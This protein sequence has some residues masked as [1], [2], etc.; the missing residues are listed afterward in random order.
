MGRSEKALEV[1]VLHCFLL[2]D[3]YHLCEETICELLFQAPFLQSK[4]SKSN[5]LL[6]RIFDSSYMLHFREVEPWFEYL[7][8]Q[9]MVNVQYIQSSSLVLTFPTPQGCEHFEYLSSYSRFSSITHGMIFITIFRNHWLLRTSLYTLTCDSVCSKSKVKDLTIF[10]NYCL[11][12]TS[13]YTFT[14]D[15]LCSKS[16]DKELTKP[17]LR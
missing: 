17:I 16:K 6:T 2:F 13:L 8:R 15:S 3:I 11:L 4:W 10:R 12:S 14:F 5:M 9:N 1:V 7:F